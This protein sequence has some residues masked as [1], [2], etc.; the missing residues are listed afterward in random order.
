VPRHRM[1]AVP[2]HGKQRPAASSFRTFLAVGRRSAVAA[3]GVS[4]LLSRPADRR[5]H[6]R[7]AP[8]SAG[9]RGRQA[10]WPHPA[11]SPRARPLRPSATGGLVGWAQGRLVRPARGRLVPAGPRQHLSRPR[12]KGKSMLKIAKVRNAG[13]D[14]GLAGACELWQFLVPART[15]STLPTPPPAV[16][17]PPPQPPRIGLSGAPSRA[18]FGTCFLPFP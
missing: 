11:G 12:K 5:A 17:L 15:L 16:L 1:H 18:R 3:G 7:W 2:R 13:Q 10:A 4:E 9:G 14:V 6:P 8:P